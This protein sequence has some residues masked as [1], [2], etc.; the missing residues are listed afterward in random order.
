MSQK[1]AHEEYHDP[2]YPV[3]STSADRPHD[4]SPAAKRARPSSPGIAATTSAPSTTAS[5]TTPTDRADHIRRIVRREFAHELNEREQELNCIEHRLQQAKRLLQR[6]RYAVVY[7]FYTNKRLVYTDSELRNELTVV[8]M[9]AGAAEETIVDPSELEPSHQPSSLTAA[10]TSD[11]PPPFAAFGSQQQSAATAAAS[12]PPQNAVHPSL[13]KL[14]G[15]TTIDYNEILK[16]RPARQAAKDA[17]TSIAEK[18]RT[19]KDERRLRLAAAAISPMQATL[20]DTTTAAPEEPVVPPKVPR[21]VSPIKSA[22]PI[23]H[24][25]TMR[26]GAMRNATRHLV[27][28]G[29]TSKFI[30]DDSG[31]PGGSQAGGVTHKWLVYVKCKQPTT[32]NAPN[33]GSGG[34]IERMVQKVRFF[35]H[36]SYKPNDVVDV[37]SAPF[38]IA[39]RGWGEFPVRVQLWFHA[40]V[41]QKPL[42]IIHQLVLDKKL[43]GLQT[44]G[45]ETVVEMWLNLPAEAAVVVKPAAAAATV[46][47]NGHSAPKLMGQL[48]KTP[49]KLNRVPIASAP[50]AAV[51]IPLEQTALLGTEPC[52]DPDGLINNVKI[53]PAEQNSLLAMAEESKRFAAGQC[54]VPVPAKATTVSP[55]QPK[56]AAVSNGT[57][58]TLVNGSGA[59]S[60]KPMPQT[61]IVI[62]S[63]PKASSTA[64]SAASSALVVN[65]EPVASK[66]SITLAPIATKAAAPVRKFVK[67]LNAAGKVVMVEL[68]TDPNNPKNIRLI[69]NSAPTIA[70]SA[71]ANVS[72]AAANKPATTV[73]V[74]S[75]AVVPTPTVEAAPKPIAGFVFKPYLMYFIVLIF[76]FRLI[77]LRTL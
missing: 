76:V 25:T 1:R 14:L 2:D 47:S 35:L 53:S 61:T 12:Q 40:H 54:M 20:R 29:N 46:L 31:D 69:R 38:Q 42:Q 3:A 43:T 50:I 49:V 7:S 63:E 30:G 26:A 15:T 5:T 32:T 13:K 55:A 39:R 59:A 72:P 17:K 33:V 36:P 18:L 67:C 27:A 22:A 44:M 9:S 64:K 28:V 57:T 65:S 41:Q 73:A 24:V 66:V 74:S 11:A 68:Q 62:N 34:G 8:S 37:C 21:Y 52:W 58:T 56:P 77:D 6:V 10:D 45:A 4:A 71:M 23:P 51:D 70:A 16:V 75:A 48:P 19:K 60:S